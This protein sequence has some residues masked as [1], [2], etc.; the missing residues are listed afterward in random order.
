MVQIL[1][2]VTGT[3]AFPLGVEWVFNRR[4]ALHHDH[5]LLLIATV[6]ATGAILA[7]NS[8]SLTNRN[9]N[10]IEHFA[11]GGVPSA[12]MYLYLCRSFRL[13]FNWLQSLAGLFFFV[14]AT[15]V[16]NELL[17]F[18]LDQTTSGVY[19]SDRWDTWYDLLANSLGALLGWLIWKLLASVRT[20]KP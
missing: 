5:L 2:L 19:S 4:R 12:L 16:L 13:R 15:G 6:I 8:H 14:S 11:G 10:F 20:I 18:V 1:L 7:T 9:V 17:E 3:I